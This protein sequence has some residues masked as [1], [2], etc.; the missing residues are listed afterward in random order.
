[1]HNGKILDRKTAELEASAIINSDNFGPEGHL[2]PV[3]KSIVSPIVYRSVVAIS[4]AIV[5]FWAGVLVGRPTTSTSIDHPDRVET[6]RPVLENGVEKIS[7]E[8]DND[9]TLKQRG[10]VWSLTTFQAKV[11]KKIS[12][13]QRSDNDAD[14]T[15]EGDN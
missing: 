6:G 13:S 2:L 11:L 15:K 1:M 14:E 4:A 9:L 8:S 12:E 10:V 7:S 3:K 5:L